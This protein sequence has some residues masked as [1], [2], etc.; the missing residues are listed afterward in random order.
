MIWIHILSDASSDQFDSIVAD[1]EFL[2]SLT[3]T[4]V[5]KLLHIIT[6]VLPAKRK[7]SDD[8][9]A[10]LKTET[11]KIRAIQRNIL[12]C[13]KNTPCGQINTSLIKLNMDYNKVSTLECCGKSTTMRSHVGQQCAVM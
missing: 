1:L 13:P 7:E 3:Q 2:L 8:L 11:D 6:T 4:H 10:L 9:R 12:A 5:P